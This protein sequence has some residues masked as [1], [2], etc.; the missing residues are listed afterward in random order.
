MQKA[1]KRALVAAGILKSVT[2]HTLRHAFCTHALQNGN[3]AATV[4]ELMGH[5]TL[6]TT[7]TYAHA[8]K[9][10]GRSPLDGP[11]LRA[12]PQATALSF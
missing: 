11:V 8:D 9:A 10:L 12:V 2:P 5:E 4:Q 7:Q 3:D 1:I 6:E